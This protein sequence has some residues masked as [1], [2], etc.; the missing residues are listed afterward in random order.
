[1]LPFEFTVL[2]P[3][4]SH[5][6]KNKARLAE[7]RGAVLAAAMAGWPTGDPPLDVPIKITV[8]YYHEGPTIR[9]DNDNMLKPIQ[10]AMNGHVYVDDRLI[11][12]ASVS[13]TPVDGPYRVRGMSRVLADAFVRDLEFLYIKIESA[14]IE[15]LLP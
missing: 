3:P 4:L 2:G 14:P 12:S 8:V 10:D 15:E 11:V 6:A 13:K 9:L 7:W 1:M 5:Q